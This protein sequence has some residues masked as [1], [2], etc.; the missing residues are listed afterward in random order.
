MAESVKSLQDKSLD[1]LLC[2]RALE[3]VP[4][5]NPFPSVAFKSVTICPWKIWPDHRELVY[6][7]SNLICK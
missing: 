3:V 4:Q 5:A 6:L 7:S 2:Q 1:I